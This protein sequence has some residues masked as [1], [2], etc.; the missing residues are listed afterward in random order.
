[1]NIR[2]ALYELAQAHRL[3]QPRM[4]ALFA[5]AELDAPPP[6]LAQRFWRTVALLA[7]GLGGFGLVMWV[8]ANWGA[9]GRTGQFALLQGWVLLTALAAWRSAALRTPMG[10]LCLLGT[11]ALFA[12]YGQTYQTGADAWQLFALWAVLTLPLCLGVRSDVLWFPWVIV[13]CS[14]ISLWAY[15]HTGHRWRTGNQDLPIHLASWAL[16]ALLVVALSPWAQRWVGTAQWSRRLALLVMAVTVTLAALA[17]LFFR[18]EGGP[19]YVLGFA[20][21]GGATGLLMQQRWFDIVGLSVAVLCVDTLLVAG[22]VRI[23]FHSSSGSDIGRLLLTGLAAAGI[24]AVS[25]GWVM[26]R[27]TA[28]LAAAQQDGAAA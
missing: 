8:A 27:Q 7:A 22:L 24:L 3:T 13:A 12:Y 28:V 18:S 15:T 17:G 25:V 23:L 19:H 20:L 4:H 11:G 9:L 2:L 14:A 1:M 5:L 26:R 21:M 10:L 16:G 6:H